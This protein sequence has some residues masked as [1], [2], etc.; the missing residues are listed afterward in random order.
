MQEDF[1]QQKEHWTNE[2]ES[3]RE[4]L[5]RDFLIEL[6][7]IKGFLVVMILSGILSV[8]IVKGLNRSRTAPLQL[9]SQKRISSFL[10][11]KR[12]KQYI[13]LLFL[14]FIR[15]QILEIV[16]KLRDEESRNT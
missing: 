14:E 6:N 3:S 2:L 9:K 4:R 12:I 15:Q 13:S 5:K 11:R 1:R 16:Q 8:T 7:R 10:R